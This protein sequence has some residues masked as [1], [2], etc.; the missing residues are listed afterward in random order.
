METRTF[1]DGYVGIKISS[2]SDIMKYNALCGSF[3]ICDES[4]Y[5]FDDYVEGDDGGDREPTSEEKLNRYVL[6]FNSG[7]TLYATFLLDCGEVVP[8]KATTLQ[9]DFR[10]GQD[11]YTMENNKI[12]KAKIDYLSLSTGDIKENAKLE[13]TNLKANA[14]SIYYRIGY[15][16]NPNGVSSPSWNNRSKIMELLKGYCLSNFAIVTIE[17]GVSL[18]RTFNELFSSKDELVKHLMEE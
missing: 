14:E 13:G 16:F 1:S 17:D 9:S 12:V 3:S 10:V 7:R 2:I 6:A 8:V 4:E 11:V 5:Y 18:K 15:M